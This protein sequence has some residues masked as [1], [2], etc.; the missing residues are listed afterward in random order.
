MKMFDSLEEFEKY[1]KSQGIISW[2]EKQQIL[3]KEAKEEM[4]KEGLEPLH[5]ITTFSDDTAGSVENLEY[6]SNPKVH[7]EVI[8]R[9]KHQT[10]RGKIAY[11]M[12]AVWDLLDWFERNQRI[13]KGLPVDETEY[14][15]LQQS[16]IF[17]SD[18][19]GE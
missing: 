15:Y 13:E 7:I 19:L 2:W 10:Y 18:E 16:T 4:I 6:F 8:F 12:F 14:L 11:E 1:R 17:Y 9:G 5:P 3:K